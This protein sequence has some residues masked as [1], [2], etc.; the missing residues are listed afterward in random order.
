MGRVSPNS[1]A[2]VWSSSKVL[3][4]KRSWGIAISL[5]RGP[6]PAYTSVR[7]GCRQA[8][9]QRGCACL[10]PVLCYTARALRR[11]GVIVRT[12]GEAV[13]EKPTKTY[14]YQQIINAWCMYDWA[15]SAFATTIMAVVLPTY[16]SSVA[17]STLPSK[18]MATSYWG[19]ANSIS[20]ILVAV[21]APILGALADHSGK[22]KLLLSRFA[23]VG[24]LAT[25]LLFF[26]S[27]GDWLLAMILYI[28]GHV[29]FSGSTIFSDALLPHI[30][31]RDD[32]DQVSSKGWALGYIG[33]G[34]LL[35]INLAWIL[36][37]AWFG[38]PNTEMAS[39]LSFLSVAIWWAVFS[40]PIFR[41]VPEPP[42]VL[43]QGE[44]QGV[45][46]GTFQRLGNTFREISK[47]KELFKFLVAF[48]LYNDGIG[49]IITMAAIYGAELG[50]G[51]TTL[52]G[53]ILMVQFVAAPFSI[54]FG[55]LSK[56]IGNKS[57]ILIG[58]GIYTVVAAYGYFVSG[59]LEFWILGFVVA[60]AQ[61]G[62]QALS[63]SL[64][65]SMSPKTKSA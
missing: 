63:R 27:T 37:P 36:K 3:R 17:G 42:A 6:P 31:T 12:K 19:Y 59:T 22:K 65:A 2:R 55:W 47:F 18:V 46:R 10:Q 29:G 8:S 41:R 15:N 20:M 23:G 21:A 45:L 34:L 14:S 48:W 9:A 24:I 52:I 30:A 49:T 54:L 26:V 7:G 5:R 38:I 33:G 25:A 53:V 4:R 64:Y 32:V 51:Q 28:I 1:V 61:G 43:E 35:L 16:F 58:L 40:I 57:T 60:M 44:S 50:I 56:R 13:A 62:S 11:G 39:R